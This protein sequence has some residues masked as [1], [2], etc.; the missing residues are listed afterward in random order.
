MLAVCQPR[1]TWRKAFSISADRP[2]GKGWNR[3]RI[4][5]ISLR[6][7]GAVSKQSFRLGELGDEWKLQSKIIRTGVVDDSF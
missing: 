2:Q 5:H 4:V 1:P 7:G 6:K 3:R